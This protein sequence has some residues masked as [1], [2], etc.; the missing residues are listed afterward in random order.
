MLTVVFHY[1]AN[2]YGTRCD[3]EEGRGREIFAFVT[4]CLNV[5]EPFLWKVGFIPFPHNDNF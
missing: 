2:P 3:G 4:T 1:I 5:F